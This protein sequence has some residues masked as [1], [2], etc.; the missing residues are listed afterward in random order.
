MTLMMLILKTWILIWTL[1]LIAEMTWNEI[2][3]A[4]C[5]ICVYFLTWNSCDAWIDAYADH[6]VHV[7]AICPAYDDFLSPLV[8]ILDQGLSVVPF[9]YHD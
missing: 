3:T 8:P 2:W 4:I 5:L 6:G 1:S 7:L 9:V